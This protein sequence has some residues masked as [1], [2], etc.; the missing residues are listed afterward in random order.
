MAIR[1]T[2]MTKEQCAQ[3]GLLSTKRVTDIK[4][5]NRLLNAE[6]DNYY[7][8]ERKYSP[9]W[10]F[11]VEEIDIYGSEAIDINGIKYPCITLNNLH[12][13]I[14]PRYMDTNG[15][16]WEA[17]VFMLSINGTLLIEGCYRST[18]KRTVFEII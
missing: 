7:F 17:D 13:R 9:Q 10:N 16:I 4:L 14:Y 15:V 18:D 3:S 2:N 12:S 6:F 11:D 5:V 1:N 8:I